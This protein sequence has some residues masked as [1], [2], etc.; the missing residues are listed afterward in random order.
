M[1]QFD[2]D[3]AALE[4]AFTE[5]ESEIKSIAEG[6]RALSKTR[7]KQD[8]IVVI[9]QDITKLNKGQ[10]NYVLNALQRLDEFTMKSSPNFTNK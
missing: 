2:I 1:A 6:M 9:L 4:K 3:E 8:T 10:I 5:L 7:L